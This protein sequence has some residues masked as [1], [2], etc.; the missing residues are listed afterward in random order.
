MKGCMAFVLCV[1]ALTAWLV[2]AGK[3]NAHNLALKHKVEMV[4]LSERITFWVVMFFMQ[5]IVFIYYPHLLYWNMVWLA[6][7]QIDRQNFINPDGNACSVC[8]I[9]QKDIP[10]KT[11]GSLWGGFVPCWPCKL[12]TLCS[13]SRTREATAQSHTR[14][15]LFLMDQ[16]SESYSTTCNCVIFCYFSSVNF[17]GKQNCCVSRNNL[18]E[19]NL[20]G[21]HQRTMFSYS[22]LY[23]MQ[24]L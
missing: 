6:K 15:H 3:T 19:S 8:Q 20:N 21:Q 1:A 5:N 17:F 23:R 4:H 2:T 12:L 24:F 10:G 14:D 13:S 9:G 22:I 7:T 16:Y 18:S 11:T